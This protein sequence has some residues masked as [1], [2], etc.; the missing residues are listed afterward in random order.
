MSAVKIIAKAIR[1]ADGSYFFEDYEKQARAVLK[2]LEADGYAV[3]RREADMA[4]FKKVSDEM[5][6]GKMKPEEH[7]KD[8]YQRVLTYLKASA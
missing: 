3:T 6:T 1:S 7:V 8:V 2:A 5:L 4:L